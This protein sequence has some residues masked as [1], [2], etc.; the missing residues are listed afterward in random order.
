MSKDILKPTRSSQECWP[1][2]YGFLR[3][4]ALLQISLS[5]ILRHWH[6]ISRHDQIIQ[7][8]HRDRICFWPFTRLSIPLVQCSVPKGKP[9][10]PRVALQYLLASQGLS[11]SR[12]IADGL[13]ELYHQAG[14][15][16]MDPHFDG[17]S[18]QIDWHCNEV[19]LKVTT[20]ITSCCQGT[21]LPWT[22]ISPG[23]WTIGR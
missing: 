21:C 16:F 7:H 15:A 17:R 13:E 11:S 10:L 5:S 12:V 18:A 6:V 20:D 23:R 4:S 19:G 3:H 9:A 8:G 22:A 14:K 1:C 2:P